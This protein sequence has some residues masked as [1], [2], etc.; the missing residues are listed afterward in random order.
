M[1]VIPRYAE[2]PLKLPWTPSPGDPEEIEQA[3]A[4]LR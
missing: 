3:A 4:Q 1:H 2:D